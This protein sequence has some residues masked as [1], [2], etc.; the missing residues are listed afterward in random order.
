MN[1]KLPEASQPSVPSSTPLTP[2]V[3]TPVQA[4]NQ[5]VSTETPPPVPP[6]AGSEI[7]LQP[8][9]LMKKLLAN[10]KSLIICGAAL[11]LLL[12]LLSVI[13]AFAMDK[14]ATKNE[15]TAKPK[16][17][18]TEKTQVAKN[19]DDSQTIV[20]GVWTS[21]QSV[22]RTVNTKTDETK[23][24][25]SL[26]LAVKK[27]SVLNNKSLIYIDHIDDNEYGK[28]VSIYN[29]QQ[30]QITTNIPAA[31]GL[32]IADYV[33]SPNK[34]YLALWEVS[35]GPDGKTLAGGQSALHTIDLTKP[36]VD[37]KLFNE[38]FATIPVHYPRAILNDG[39]VFTDTYLPTN[40]Q[41]DPGWENGLSVIDFD[42]TNQKDIAA[43]TAGT[44]SSQPVL[45]PDQKYLL[46]TGYDGSSGDGTATRNGVRQAILSANTVEILNTSSLKR[47]KLPNLPAGTLYGTPQW[48]NFTGD[49]IIPILSSTSTQRGIYAYDLGKQ[50]L[51]K[52]PF[53]FPGSIFL[54]QLPK[55]QTL[56]GTQSTDK[57]NLG[58]LG[59]T[60]TY[61]FTQLSIVS[62][63]AEPEYLSAE[64][65]YIQYITVLPGNYFALK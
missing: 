34:R 29:L 14:P 15:N 52:L 11:V 47:F 23:T 12:I 46:F 49:P 3:A 35:L 40:V 22:I 53:T 24:L 64:D 43:A 48:D 7:P 9:T 37:N 38:P 50:S 26:P 59:P 30:K 2:V 20:Y 31:P 5:P 32:S 61:A 18:A 39:T 25:V 60:D 19:P 58:N 13:L 57:A 51:T 42:G 4:T 63:N 6:Q 33:L 45:S 27:I 65:P 56:I 44:Y 8:P 62:A 54:A 1:P 41:G 28:R 21:Q 17:Q 10:K 36:T 16:E 55:A